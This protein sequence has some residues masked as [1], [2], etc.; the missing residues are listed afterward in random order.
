MI[1]TQWHLKTCCIYNNHKHLV[2]YLKSQYTIGMKEKT[3]FNNLQQ[4]LKYCGVTDAQLLMDKLW[5]IMLEATA[6]WIVT[7]TSPDIILAFLILH[8][9]TTE[10]FKTTQ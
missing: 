9:L 10:I 8:L 2:K 4:L 1:Q 7:K 5:R 6:I 3:R